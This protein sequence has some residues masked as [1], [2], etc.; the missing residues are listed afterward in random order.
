MCKYHLH[1]WL[2]SRPER[3]SAGG[4]GG[5]GACRW[6][7]WCLQ[8][9]QP[10]FQCFHTVSSQ[11]AAGGGAAAQL[12]SVICGDSVLQSIQKYPF[13]WFSEISNITNIS[14]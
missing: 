12:Q 5:G 11:S 7:R 1:S 13:N 3:G 10:M 9:E 4:G 6:W 2:G 14:T 8:V